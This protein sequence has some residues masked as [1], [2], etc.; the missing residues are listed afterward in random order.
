[1]Q[2]V[3]RWIN[4][5]L[6]RNLSSESTKAAAVTVANIEQE[7]K[8]VF[9]TLSQSGRNKLTRRV[10]ERDIPGDSSGYDKLEFDLEA[11]K[12]HYYYKYE[13]TKN[14]R[15]GAIGIRRALELFHEMKAKGR[16]E[17]ALENFA[18]LIYGCAKAGFT[19]RAFELYEESLRY[20]RKPTNSIITCLINSCGESPF[21]EYGLQRLDWFLKH[22]KVE[23][24]KCFN[25][26][27]YNSAIKAY[28]K[29]G[30]LDEAARLIQEM[31]DNEV[32][33]SI[34]TF[35]MLLIG[36]A[37]NKGAGCL[38]ALRVYKRIKM[39]QIKPDLITY[40]LLLRC[41]RDCDL[42][43]PELV[44]AAIEE[45]P[46][47]TSLNERI[48]YQERVG[49]RTPKSSSKPAMAWVP[50]ISDM[51][52]S[53]AEAVNAPERRVIVRRQ[54]SSDKS[55]TKTAKETSVQLAD[56]PRSLDRTIAELMPVAEHPEQMLPN[57]L[58][59]DHL[60]LVTCI[61]AIQ[62]D[63]IK[64]ARERLLLFGGLHGFLATMMQNDCKPDNKTFSL[65]LNC[66]EPNRENYLNYHKLAQQMNIKRDLIYYDL[67]IQHICIQM[68]NTSRL[69]LALYFV[70]QMHLDNLRPSIST[71]E[72]LAGGCHDWKQA[73]KLMEDLNKCGFIVSDVM[74]AR[75]FGAAC[76]RYNYAY[77]VELIR[78]CGRVN[79]SPNKLLVDKL[80]SLRLRMNE[81]ILKRERSKD[82]SER[83]LPEQRVK[84]FD[85]FRLCLGAWLKKVDVQ[86]EEHPWSQFQVA[87]GSKNENFRNYVKQME[88]AVHAKREALAKGETLANP[89]LI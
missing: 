53:F 65:L 41:I 81:I 69:E 50:L 74:I 20:C 16:I 67:L 78:H 61:E 12:N 70:E 35:N 46:A 83:P 55:A 27:Q 57:L 29:L 25:E 63:K 39:Y 42:G 30:R 72:A 14:A 47:V 10:A 21:P 31:I 8:N 44:A 28:G 48:D 1:M 68:R 15:L 62:F 64:S 79:F 18:P 77:L 80:E 82:S 32:Y 26:V 51:G 40:R 33:P 24:N 23:Y 7:P 84:D 88:A 5:R 85:E 52:K 11:R 43:S 22:V 34:Q 58:S 37:S 4:L 76:S 36:C 13:I 49:K 17:P 9:G 56:I 60:S 38:F 6:V 87:H 75:F 54:G 71:F 86:E 45:L 59:T 73:L 66:L 89:L 2:R 19:K 3:N